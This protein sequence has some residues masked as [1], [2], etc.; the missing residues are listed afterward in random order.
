MRVYESQGLKGSV[1]LDL[2][3]GITSAKEVDFNGSPR[4]K[5]ISVSGNSVHFEIEPWEIVTLAIT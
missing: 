5:T 2:P 1:V 3:I 4:Q